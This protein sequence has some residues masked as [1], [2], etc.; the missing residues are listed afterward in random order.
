MD[1][2]LS[3]ALIDLY[4]RTRSKFKKSDVEKFITEII[5]A[6][7]NEIILNKSLLDFYESQFADQTSE[8]DF[9]RDEFATLINERSIS[10]AAAHN[11]I[12]QL[13]KNTET[14][15]LQLPRSRTYINFGRSST[16]ST[17]S[18]FSATIDNLGDLRDKLFFELAANGKKGVTYWQHNF[19]SN[20]MVKDFFEI[21]YDLRRN[22]ALVNH[23]NAFVSV[24]HTYHDKLI[25]GGAR[26]NYYTAIGN[27]AFRQSDN[28]R[29][30][31]KYRRVN[32]LRGKRKQIHER[33]L[34]FMDLL[35]EANNDWENLVVNETTWKIDVFICSETCSAIIEKKAPHFR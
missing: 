8:R 33:R 19:N 28:E 15:Y 2:L 29:I 21:I 23:F 20:K 31:Q 22:N 26:F 32:I 10:V 12:Q 16:D 25:N 35:V 4:V 1:I 17:Q 30:T 5:E 7:C 34:I 13:L 3:P 18:R 6:Q 24:N 9:F 11:D 14:K 27:P